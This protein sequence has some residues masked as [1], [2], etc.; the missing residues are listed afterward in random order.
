[1]YDKKFINS[2]FSNKSRDN[3]NLLTEYDLNYNNKTLNNCSYNRNNSYKNNCKNIINDKARNK[4]YI[5][6]FS[7]NLLKLN[8]FMTKNNSN[9]NKYILTNNSLKNRYGININKNYSFRSS[10][11]LTK[12]SKN[13][14][15]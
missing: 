12:H 5:R 1:M 14:I 4:N 11:N 9:K 7:N 2:N 6:N 8:P 10:I 15:Q 13:I 3:S